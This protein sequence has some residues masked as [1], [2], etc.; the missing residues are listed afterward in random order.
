ERFSELRAIWNRG[1][2]RDNAPEVIASARQAFERACREG[3][4]PADIIDAAKTWFAAAEAADGPRYL[5]KLH[6]WLDGRSFEQPPPPTKRGRRANDQKAQ[7]SSGYAKPD[8]FK[9]CLEAGGYREDADG[10]PYWPGDGGGDDEPISTS[11]WG[12]GR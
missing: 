2:A 4:K 5:P 1:H 8:M 12:G 11:M 7:R 10:N 6:E 3:A 9:I